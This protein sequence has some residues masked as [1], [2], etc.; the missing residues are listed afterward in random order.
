[1]Y[2]YTTE[3]AS[4]QYVCKILQNTL[5]KAE[6]EGWSVVHLTYDP[7]RLVGAITDIQQPV[8]GYFMAI[9]QRRIDA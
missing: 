8:D 7:P 2:E 6:Q 4:G 1:M 5:K 3:E 9:L